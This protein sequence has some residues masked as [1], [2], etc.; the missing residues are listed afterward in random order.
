MLAADYLYAPMRRTA[1]VLVSVFAVALPGAASARQ[2]SRATEMQAYLHQMA[3]LYAK[4]VKAENRLDHAELGMLDGKVTD[5]ELKAADQAFKP[6]VR[7]AYIGMKAVQPPA[8]LRGP[9]AGLLLTAKAEYTERWD[10][11]RPTRARQM[12]ALRT[13]WR[14]EVIFQLRYAGLSVPL[15]VKNVRWVYY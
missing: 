1:L 5:A 13:Q 4:I 9:H 10:G 11:S 6:D 3:P 15:W 12:G 7:A 14:Q 8:V 2:S